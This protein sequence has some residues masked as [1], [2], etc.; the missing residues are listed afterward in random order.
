VTGGFTFSA[1]FYTPAGPSGGL[2]TP[3]LFFFR[4]TKKNAR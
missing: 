3:V 2:C 1:F 4:M